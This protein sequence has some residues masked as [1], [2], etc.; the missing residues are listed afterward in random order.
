[1]SAFYDSFGGLKMTNKISK[2]NDDLAYFN[3]RL[4]EV[5]MT[6]HERLRAKAH[7]AR[8]EAMADLVARAIS[9]IARI[10]KHEQVRTNHPA[11]SAG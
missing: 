2:S 5:R 4:D 9:G 11:A 8:A 1:M 3:G 7:L 6:S 10:F